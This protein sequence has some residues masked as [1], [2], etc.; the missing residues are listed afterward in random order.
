MAAVLPS[1]LKTTG[2]TTALQD[3]GKLTAMTTFIS[4]FH[5]IQK[6]FPLRKTA[7]TGPTFGLQ[8]ILNLEQVTN[9][10]NITQLESCFQSAEIRI[11]AVM[12]L[13]SAPTF[14]VAF[15][16]SNI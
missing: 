13:N 10:V 7:V 16:R 12:T 4:V 15:C 9:L 2:S 6:L 8:L 1:T 3:P 5:F 14:V 11:F